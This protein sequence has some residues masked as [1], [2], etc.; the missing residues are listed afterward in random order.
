[1]TPIELRLNSHADAY[2]KRA[3]PPDGMHTR[4]VREISAPRRGRNEWVVRAVVA[5]FPVLA[6]ATLVLRAYDHGPQ[7]PV[8]PPQPI[9]SVAPVRSPDHVIP[10]SPEIGVP[11][12]TPQLGAGPALSAPQRSAPTAVGPRPA[13][14]SPELAA[15]P[16]SGQAQTSPGCEATDA[17]AGGLGSVGAAQYCSFTAGAAGGY[18]GVGFWYM[19]VTRAGVTRSYDQS[20]PRCS[21]TGF[22]QPGDYVEIGVPYGQSGDIKAGETAHC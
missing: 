16:P 12:A 2:R 18:S 13:S 19:R 9:A 15:T 11:T 7:H 17:G 14:P 5:S 21:S 20:A 4:I 3:T 22:I 8:R 1:M 6:L 10:A